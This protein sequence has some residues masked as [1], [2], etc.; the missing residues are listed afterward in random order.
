MTK[1][2]NH[3]SKLYY[4]AAK[5]LGLKTEI[6]DESGVI[7]ISNKKKQLYFIKAKA[8]INSIT[9]TVLS[10]NKFLT[11]KTL[12]AHQIPAL[13]LTT[14]RFEDQ[15]PKA[16]KKIGFPLVVKPRTG[17]E[18]KAVYV[19]LQN[20]KEVKTAF[21]S[22]NKICK[23][24]VFEKYFAGSDYR[25]LILE[26]RVLAILKKEPPQVTGDGIHNLE[27]LIK[28][29]NKKRLIKHKTY[30]SGLK[31]NIVLGK[32]ALLF[33][34]KQGIDLNYVP[35]K[36]EVVVLKQKANL[37]T[38]GSSTLLNPKDF[39]PS[40]IKTAIK[41][42]KVFNLKL[43]AVD[44]LIKNPKKPLTKTNATILETNSAPGLTPFYYPINGKP[45]KVAE[46][47]LKY[48]FQV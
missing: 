21:K 12:K 7:K 20:L 5:N 33:L 14:I 18:G 11:Y 29:E 45:H 24:V 1:L 15:I 31:N 38:G 17:G 44:L 13:R 10:H 37:T 8:P 27:F 35:K 19:R 48:I 34:Q 4:Q 32:P 36:N 39:H 41:T 6:I 40:I 22:A 43:A 47:I 42:A 46:D 23:E 3:T 25:F 28:E 16:I 2:L 26:D 30:N 9:S